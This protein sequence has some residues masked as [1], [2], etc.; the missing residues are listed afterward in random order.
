[1]YFNACDNKF[2]KQDVHLIFLMQVDK[3]DDNGI[4]NNI[5]EICMS[6][7]PRYSATKDQI[8]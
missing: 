5:Q 4:T 8:V 2:K 7:L 1:M 6:R 3:D